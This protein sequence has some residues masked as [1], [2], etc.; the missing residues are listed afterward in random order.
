MSYYDKSFG[1][2]RF[3]LNYGREHVRRFCQASTP[4]QSV[5]DLGAGSGADLLA[6]R[7]AC[8]SAQLY[9]VEVNPGFATPLVNQGIEVFPIDLERDP[10]PLPDGSVDLVIANQVLEHLKDLYWVFHQVSRILPVRG[11]WIVGVP[12]L[13]SLHNRVLLALG[14]QPTCIKSNSAHVRG[15]TRGDFQQFMEE[16]FPGG[17]TVRE[18]RGANFYPFPPT[19]ARPLARALP[20]LAWGMFFL[21]EKRREYQREFLDAP[22]DQQLETNFYVGRDE[23]RIGTRLP[24]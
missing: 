3:A 19:L 11:H 23:D 22:I 17:Y 5:I 15:F 1:P 16:I 21:F 24:V 13:A 14:I 8:P 12:N 2:I 10:I 6:A 20:S 9:A 18:F 7:S 4:Y